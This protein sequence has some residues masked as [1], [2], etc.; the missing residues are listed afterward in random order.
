MND[1][2][3]KF[4]EKCFNCGDLIE[5]TVGQLI[6]KAPLC[7]KCRKTRRNKGRKSFCVSTGTFKY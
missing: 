6:N 2:K 4:K 1:T 3:P 5:G 7:D